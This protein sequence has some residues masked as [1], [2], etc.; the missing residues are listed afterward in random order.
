ML[1]FEVKQWGSQGEDQVLGI[2]TSVW[3][4]QSLFNPKSLQLHLDQSFNL[5]SS[6]EKRSLLWIC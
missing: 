4:V 6:F 1:A 3:N 5:I 2:H